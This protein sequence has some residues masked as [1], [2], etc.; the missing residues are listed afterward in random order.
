MTKKLQI[1]NNI[2]TSQFEDINMINSLYVRWITNNLIPEDDLLLLKHM[3]C[4]EDIK[5]R[6]DFYMRQIDFKTE[7][8][9]LKS[10]KD[11]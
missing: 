1:P 10:S 9:N 11:N 5:K 3:E 6:E 8:N 7:Q 2:F 4:L